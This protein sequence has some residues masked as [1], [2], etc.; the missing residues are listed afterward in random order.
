MPPQKPVGWIHGLRNPRRRWTSKRT[1]RRPVFTQVVVDYLSFVLSANTHGAYG[2]NYR[3]PYTFIRVV[4]P[5]YRYRYIPG[6]LWG[7]KVILRSCLHAR[8]TFPVSLLVRCSSLSTI[9]RFHRGAASFHRPSGR[10]REAVPP[11]AIRTPDNL[12]APRDL[13]YS[14]E[15][16]CYLTLLKIPT[17]SWIRGGHD[18]SASR[19]VS[20]FKKKIPHSRLLPLSRPQVIASF[21]HLQLPALSTSAGSKAPD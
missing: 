13:Y 2:D 15:W 20:S 9:P 4:H 21:I 16:Y 5:E 14:T 17:R 11:T 12:P 7:T 1:S 8:T 3:T 6:A 19:D 10:S 18:V